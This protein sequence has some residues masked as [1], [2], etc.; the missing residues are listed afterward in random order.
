MRGHQEEITNLLRQALEYPSGEKR[1]ALLYMLSRALVRA[2]YFLDNDRGRFRLGKRELTALNKALGTVVANPLDLEDLNLYKSTPKREA[3]KEL[4]RKLAVAGF[5]DPPAGRLHTGKGVKVEGELVVCDSCGKP[6][7]EDYGVIVS[8]W[9]FAASLTDEGHPTGGI[10]GCRGH[11]G[12]HCYCRRCFEKVMPWY[13]KPED[14]KR[15]D[16]D[17]IDHLLAEMFAEGS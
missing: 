9:V 3:Y 10:I 1:D 11:M 7:E 6:V 15:F 12:P 4:Y 14:P 8:G 2:G 17:E 16:D 5:S 13:G